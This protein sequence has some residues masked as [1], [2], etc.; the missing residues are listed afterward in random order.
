[1]RRV[2]FGGA[3]GVDDSEELAGAGAAGDIAGNVVGGVR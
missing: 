2:D 3:A 1:M